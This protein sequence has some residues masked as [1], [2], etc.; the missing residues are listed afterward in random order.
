MSLIEFRSSSIQRSQT[1]ISHTFSR[2]CLARREWLISALGFP[3]KI[4]RYFHFLILWRQRKVLNFLICLVC[5]KQM[6]IEFSAVVEKVW[7]TST[8]E[9]C[10]SSIQ[11]TQSSTSAKSEKPCSNKS[12]TSEAEPTSSPKAP[13]TTYRD[14]KVALGHF[15]SQSMTKSGP[16]SQNQSLERRRKRWKNQSPNITHIIN[17]SS[18][19]SGRIQMLHLLIMPS[20]RVKNQAKMSP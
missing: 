16:R 2:I 20:F 17:I 8:L 9:N 12:M 3:I 19:A 18:Q 5:M 13:S 1:L 14:F 11:I 15:S 7:K 6:A 10:L 4:R